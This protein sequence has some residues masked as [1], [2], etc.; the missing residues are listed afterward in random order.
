MA[1]VVRGR[2]RDRGV[3]QRVLP[4]AGASAFAAWAARTPPDFDLAVKISRYL[5]HILRLREPGEP[6]ERIPR[7]CLRLG[8]KL[9]PV[10]LQLPPSLEAEPEPL[11]EVLRRLT[12]HV[13]VAV[14]FRHRSWF[15]DDD[16]GPAGAARRGPV[17]DGS[18]PADLASGAPPIGR[19][20]ASTRVGRGR[21]RATAEPPSTAGPNGWRRMGRLARGLGLLQ[22]RHERCCAVRNVIEFASSIE[23]VRPSLLPRPIARRGTNC[24]MTSVRRMAG[25]EVG[26]RYRP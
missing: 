22:Q 15:T 16:A 25:R 20:C 6:V 26:R 2:V 8:R 9:G 19:T 24:G 12:P 21:G 23:R 14:E 13:R 11:D 1:R 4:P 5:T 3:E 7:S 10:L 18:T 17:P